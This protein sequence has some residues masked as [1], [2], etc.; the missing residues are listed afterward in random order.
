MKLSKKI[1]FLRVENNMSQEKLAEV[2]DVSRQSI[3]KY[4]NGS[5]VPD[6]EKLTKIVKVF[7]VT[8][9]Y[10]LNDEVDIIDSVRKSVD[11]ISNVEY[12]DISD[13]NLN[14]SIKGGKVY[15][16]NIY[17]RNN[18]RN[19]NRNTD[20]ISIIDC[21]GKILSSYYKFNV[22]RVFKPKNNQ[23]YAMLL[24]IDKHTFWGENTV[25]LGWYASEEDIKNE[26]EDIYK[27]IA[28]K[29]KN[30]RLKYNVKIKKRGLID[31]EIDDCK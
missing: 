3:S 16:S 23:P 8:Y 20:K 27:A 15:T 12:S 13:E 2:L 17:N 31:I 6:Y 19:N 14:R 21:T 1:K 26:I 25:P 18:D 4:E 7:D 22:S 10:L 5:S 24:G 9:D 29:Q 30:Y 28:N 11:G